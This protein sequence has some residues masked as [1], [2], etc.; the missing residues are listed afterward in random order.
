MRSATMVLETKHTAAADPLR[1]TPKQP[2]RTDSHGS[3][4]LR[5]LLWGKLNIL[6]ALP[7]PGNNLLQPAAGGYP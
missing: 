6:G 3:D 5:C 7:K 2:Q 1:F 4:Y